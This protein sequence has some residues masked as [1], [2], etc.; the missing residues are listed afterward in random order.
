MTACIPQ[1]N[2]KCAHEPTAHHLLVIFDQLRDLNGGAEHAL[3]KIIRLLPP[4]KFRASIA[5]FWEPSDPGFLSQFQ[6][7]VHFLPLTKTYGLESIRVARRLRGIIQ[8]EQV[9]I[10]QTFFET[11]DLWGGLIAKLSGCPIL[12]SSRRDMGFLRTAK[13]RLAYRLLS[14]LFDQVHTVSEAV[15]EFTIREDRIHPDKV[16]T[17]P[18]GVDMHKIPA[19]RQTARLRARYGL[20]DASHVIADVGSVKPVKGYEVM[21][22]AAAVVCQK[23]PEAVFVVIGSTPDKSYLMQLKSLISALGLTRN[24][25][26]I[27]H[28]DDVFPLLQMSDIFCHLS[29][30]DGLSNALLEAMATGLPSVISRVGGN[31]EVVEEGL[32][33]FVV[34]PG[35]HE[36]AAER[37]LTLIS[38][39]YMAS[40]MGDRGRQ[41]IERSFTAEAMVR[42]L[43]D[44]Y[45]GLLE[46][47]L[48]LKEEKV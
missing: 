20:E 26:F 17:V 9:S 2:P 30:T 27:G 40:V 15:R 24:F 33:G 46:S 25:R 37:I 29:V 8:T 39:P 32:S 12:V 38:N 16:I 11:S 5:T 31:P 4:D 36:L 48:A 23:H 7:P 47:K 34:A 14:P 13:H 3:L 1:H 6:C 19:L 18:N 35:D 41:I 10:V 28:S 43:V 22:R 21:A 44:L 42:K 45:E